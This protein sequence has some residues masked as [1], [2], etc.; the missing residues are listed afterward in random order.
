[1][2]GKHMELIV[3]MQ[4]TSY[5]SQLEAS[6]LFQEVRDIL[7]LGDIVLPVTCTC[8]CVMYGVCMAEETLECNSFLLLPLP[9]PTHLPMPNHH[10]SHPP[11]H[12][13]PSPC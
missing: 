11:T 2:N 1:M 12:M 3:N 4:L 8:V 13:H 6:A 7:K 9:P 5:W 10:P